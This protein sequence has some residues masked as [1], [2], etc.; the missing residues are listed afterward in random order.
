MACHRGTT[1]A[2]QKLQ[3]SKPNSVRLEPWGFAVDQ[4]GMG[5]ANLGFRF[6]ATEGPY[7]V[8]PL[9]EVERGN[10]RLGKTTCPTYPHVSF[11]PPHPGRH[12]HDMHIKLIPNAR[13]L[14]I[15]SLV[16]SDVA[17]RMNQSEGLTNSRAGVERV[18]CTPSVVRGMHVYIQWTWVGSEQ[19]DSVASRSP[20]GPSKHPQHLSLSVCCKLHI[21]PSLSPFSI[22]CP[23]AS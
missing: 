16:T 12:Q 3:I 23:R 18:L 11:S 10:K 9:P 6:K 22:S 13:S 20:Q 8:R 19:T 7:Q 1:S 4:G 21:P 14:A 15:H 17:C 5:N 2:H